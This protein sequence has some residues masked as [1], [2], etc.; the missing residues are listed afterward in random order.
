M[1]PVFVV[2]ATRNATEEEMRT[3][4]CLVSSLDAPGR[5]EQNC[6]LT[7]LASPTTILSTNLTYLGLAG[8][9]GRYYVG[10]T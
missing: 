7:P 9:K 4:C 2:A 8:S 10:I 1:E 6:P 3:G 5:N